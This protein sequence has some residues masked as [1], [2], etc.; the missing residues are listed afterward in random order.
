MENKILP[1]VCSFDINT[2]VNTIQQYT[3]QQTL[4]HTCCILHSRHSH[5]VHYT[6]DTHMH[7]IMPL[8]VT[9][10]YMHTSQTPSHTIMFILD[11]THRS[12]CPLDPTHSSNCHIRLRGPYQ[13]PHTQL[14]PYQT[15]THNH[16]HIK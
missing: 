15:L 7:A 4:T 14:Y 5:V 2:H 6:A 10:L 3:A 8:S 9:S 16:A 13:T 11:P 1:V 12:N